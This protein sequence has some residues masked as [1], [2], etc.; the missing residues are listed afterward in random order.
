MFQGSDE[1]IQSELPVFERDVDAVI[2]THAHIDH[3]GRLPVL[4]R[5]GFKGGI[6]CTKATVELC[7]ILLRDCAHIHLGEVERANRK[8]ER[9][10]RP[11]IEPDFD[12][13]DVEATIKLLRPVDYEAKVQITQD[14]DAVFLDAGHIL[15]SSSLVVNVSDE[16]ETRKLV[17]SGD[18]G[19]CD[20]P[21]LQDPTHVTSADYVIMESTYGDRERPPERDVRSELRDILLE[22]FERNGNVVIPAFA[23]GR[24]QEL[25]YYLREIYT[26]GELG[27]YTQCPVFMD[28]PLAIEA[29]KIYMENDRGYYDDEAIELV[30]R[31]C[32]P[33][34]FPQ[35]RIAQTSEESQ[36]I[37]FFGGSCVIISASGMCEAG[38]I[39]HHL[40]HNLWRKRSS[41]VF[42][43]YQA[44]GTLGRTLLDGA[45]NIKLFGEEI[46]VEASIYKIE[47]MSAHADRKGLEDWISTFSP[48]PTRVFVNHG[49][50]DSAQSFA[51]LLGQK[52]Y[53]AIAPEMGESYDLL[54][55]VEAAAPVRTAENTRAGLYDRITTASEKLLA[56][57]HSQLRGF[58]LPGDGLDM[59]GMAD[60]TEDIEALVQKYDG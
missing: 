51:Q 53:A 35:L 2:L 4:V 59:E 44:N 60:L 41:I 8:N 43:G 37:N 49:E 16:G 14:I 11:L 29:T 6:Y 52:G 17:F 12:M 23:V 55:A 22:T 32:S 47:G 7:G 50:R 9:A 26:S 56:L 3:S 18:I 46:N 24:T 13:A 31:G 19:A 48:K 1:D 25:L 57:I 30:N 38:R 28:S 45:K 42:T 27:S 34:Q 20:R 10:G 54:L 33:M 39:R 58:A 15:G 5:H 36:E 40:K 21:I